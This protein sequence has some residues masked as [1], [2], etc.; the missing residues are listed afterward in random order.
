M[1][2]GRSFLALAALT[3]SC[4]RHPRAGRVQARRSLQTG[5]PDRCPGRTAACRSTDRV[6]V[7]RPGSAARRSSSRHAGLEGRHGSRGARRRATGRLEGVASSTVP[8]LHVVRT[9][10]GGR[11]RRDSR[12]AGAPQ[13]FGGNRARSRVPRAARRSISRRKRNRPSGTSRRPSS[14]GKRRRPTRFAS[15]LAS[16][17]P[18][19]R[20]V[21]LRPTNVEGRA[22][23]DRVGAHRVPPRIPGGNALGSVVAG[24][25]GGLPGDRS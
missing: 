13:G 24:A 18:S 8:L 17:L 22:L 3:A 12:S 11:P 2:K 14:R 1:A 20:H 23:R 16:W 7:R 25:V 21:V 10:D 19:I 6:A 15:A 9:P 5:Q 4:S